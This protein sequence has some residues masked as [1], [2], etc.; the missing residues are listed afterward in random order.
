MEII[1]R[2]QGAIY[3]E[4]Y[5]WNYDFEKLV[6]DIA[7]AFEKSFDPEKEYCWVAERNG[8]IIGSIF[9]VR[10]SDDVAKLRLL[11]VESSARGLGLGRRLVDECVKFARQKGYKTLTL[12]T[13][14]V[15][16]SARKIYENAGFKLVKEE[17]HHSFGKDLVGQNWDLDLTN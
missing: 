4:E 1:T 10:Q 9:L 11:Y 13:N 16:T 2:R 14:S 6:G 15:L 3:L 17:A 12:W 8:E 7:Q 5:G